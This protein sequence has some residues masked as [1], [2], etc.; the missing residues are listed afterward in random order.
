MVEAM[1]PL[2][3]EG[4]FR[5]SCEVTMRVLREQ[6]T[7]L[8]SVLTPFVYDPLLS[9]ND[10]SKEL[11]KSGDPDEKTNER[12]NTCLSYFKMSFLLSVQI[13][14]INNPIHLFRLSCK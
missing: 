7:T 10:K 1:G 13:K 4:P 11:T 6:T 12:V 8:I 2:K 3:Y 9:W 14:P 5:R